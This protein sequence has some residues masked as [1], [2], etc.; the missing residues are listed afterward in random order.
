MPTL[1][2]STNVPTIR[3]WAR[4]RV[5]RAIFPVYYQP[6]PEKKQALHQLLLEENPLFEWFSSLYLQ[7]LRA[8]LPMASDDLDLA[9]KVMRRIYEH[10]GRPLP[11]FFSPQPFETLFGSGRLEWNDLLT[12]IKKAQ[13]IDEGS[14]LRIEFTK[15]MQAGDVAYYESLLPLKLDKDRK[16]NTLLIKA[17]GAFR[18]WLS[19]EFESLSGQISGN[20]PAEK[21]GLVSRMRRRFRKRP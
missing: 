13:V 17:P 7:D 18:L 4:T 15:D 11:S 10:A 8:D 14:R 16:G 21:T 20:K 1:I 3:D 19:G 2:F 5:T 12:G 9:R 6:D